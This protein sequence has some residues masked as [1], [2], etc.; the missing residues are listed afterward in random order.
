[1]PADD[2]E[3]RKTINRS[4]RFR[5]LAAT[6]GCIALST[7][8]DGTGSGRQVAARLNIVAGDLQTAWWA[9]G[10]VGLPG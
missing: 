2:Q 8:G 1:M 7:C 10:Q 4:F 5:V 3:R 6:A 9:T